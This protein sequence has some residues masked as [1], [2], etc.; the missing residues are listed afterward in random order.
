MG[1]VVLTAC[2]LWASTGGSVAGK[3]EEDGRVMQQSAHYPRSLF[4]A[5]STPSSAY[6][7]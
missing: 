7:V 6:R 5:Q 1:A 3:R 4:G 2:A